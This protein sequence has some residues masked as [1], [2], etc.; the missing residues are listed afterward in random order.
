MRS[1][2]IWKLHTSLRELSTVGRHRRKGIFFIGRSEASMWKTW[3]CTEIQRKDEEGFKKLKS[4]KHA[5]EK[6]IAF[7]AE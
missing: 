4:R 2:D 3:L 1:Q 7:Q 6:K 5:I